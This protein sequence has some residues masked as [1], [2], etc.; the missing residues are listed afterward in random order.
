MYETYL[1]STGFNSFVFFKFVL[2]V[3]LFLYKNS[4]MIIFLFSLMYDVVTRTVTREEK[5]PRDSKTKIY[6]TERIVRS[7]E[8]T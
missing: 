5:R 1:S 4:I 6:D 7:V 2:G 8:L 3:Y